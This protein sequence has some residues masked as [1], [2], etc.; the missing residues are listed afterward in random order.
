MSRSILLLLASI[1]GAYL[2]CAQDLNIPT[3][4][5][6]GGA[7]FSNGEWITLREIEHN[8]GKPQPP[9]LPKSY[10]RDATIFVSLQ[11]YRDARCA[12]TVDHLLKRAKYPDRVHI[13]TKLFL[14]LM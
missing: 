4:P 11:H 3:P 1:I 9:K 8:N 13:G 7:I 6:D 2:S 12:T 14:L 10:L 5:I